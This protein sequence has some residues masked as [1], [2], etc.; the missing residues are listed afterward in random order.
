MKIINMSEIPYRK[1]S[2]SAFKC[3]Q[4]HEESEAF[5]GEIGLFESKIT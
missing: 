2:R 5:D 4:P 1:H 3:F